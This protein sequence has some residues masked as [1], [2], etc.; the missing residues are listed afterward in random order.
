[1]NISREERA[2]C[3]NPAGPRLPPRLLENL[4]LRF[5]LSN[6]QALEDEL[7]AF[8]KD[9]AAE[10]IQM[11]SRL[12]AITQAEGRVAKLL[13]AANRAL[14]DG[15]FQAADA[16]LAEAEDDQLKSTTLAALDRQCD[17]RFARGQ[18]ALLA[19][20]IDKAAAHWEAAANY[21]HFLDRAA[22]AEKRFTYC[23]DLRAYGYRYRN[24]PALKAARDALQA[25]LSIW[26][27]EVSLANWCRATIALGGANW[28][29][30]QFDDPER[31]SAHALAARIAYEEVRETCSE[32]ILPY[33]YALSGGSLASL[34]ADRELSASDPEYHDSLALGLQ[35][36]H[37]A[38]NALCKVD[39]AIAW[40]IFQHNIGLSYIHFFK[41][42]AD[43]QTSLHLVD[44]A[45]DHLERS[46]EVRDPVDMLQYWIAS[47]RSLGEA[48][49]E[50]AACQ[51]GGKAS[52]TLKR[53][54]VLLAEATSK[55]AQAEHPHQWAELQNQLARCPEKA[56]A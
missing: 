25:N 20:D 40:G 35:I 56:N 7:E 2:A 33:Y 10:F 23:D 32:T 51:S 29:L 16:R 54:R 24:V 9:K 17:L 26:T 6:P 41:L 42:Q 14:E 53:A 55:I 34:Y 46:F 39:H 31:F 11:Q 22:E 48:L 47:R 15:D 50:K 3:H 8:L 4:A 45:I 5:G 37:S 13:E 52:S 28:R 49:I 18:A 43:R 1:L 38:L 21:F 19:G 30:S 44:S 36:Q 12:D 27:R